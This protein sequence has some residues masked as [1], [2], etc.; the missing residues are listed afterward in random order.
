MVWREEWCLILMSYNI[1]QRPSKSENVL[2]HRESMRKNV[3][4]KINQSYC[5]L[6]LAFRLCE[7]CSGR[8]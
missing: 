5:I 6:V 3:N 8:F 1:C 2:K 4:P 7:N